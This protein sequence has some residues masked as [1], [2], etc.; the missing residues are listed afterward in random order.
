MWEEEDLSKKI[1]LKKDD[2]VKVVKIGSGND[3]VSKFFKF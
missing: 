2:N 3:G 1:E